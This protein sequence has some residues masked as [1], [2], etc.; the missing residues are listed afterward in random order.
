MIPEHQMPFFRALLTTRRSVALVATVLFATS[1]SDRPL[2]IDPSA[3]EPQLAASLDVASTSGVVISQVYGGGGTSG[4]TLRNDFVELFNAG[5][6][7]VTLTGWSIQYASATGTSWQVTNLTGTIQPGAYY[8][9][10][11]AQGSG[12]TANLPTPDASGSIAMSA[13]NGK[14]AL[15]L[16]QTALSGS[17][18]TTGVAD[19]VGFGSTANCFE[20]A[21]ATPTLS[22]TT[23]A[24]R[25]TNGCADTDQNGDDFTTGT[26]APRNS[27]TA[28]IVCPPPPP[29]PPATVASITPAD[30]ALEAPLNTNIA[31]TFSRAVTA[32]ATAFSL[33]CSVSGLVTTTRTGGPTAFTLDPDATL[34]Q[35]ET[36]TV[37]VQATE[38]VNAANIPMAADFT[39]SFT[40]A[41]PAACTAPFTPIFAI[42]GNGASAAITGPAVTQGVVVGDYEGPSPTL[43]GFYLQALTGDGNTATSDGIFVFNGSNNNVSLGDIVRVSGTAADFQDQTQISASTVTVCGTGTVTPV[44]VTLPVPSADYLERFE[45]MLVRFPQAL[46]VTEHFQ[47]GRFGQVVMS[48]GGRLAQPTNVFAPGAAALVLQAQNNLNRIIV[49]DALQNQNADPILFGRGGSP[50]SASSTLRGGDQATG[51][52]GVLTYTWAGNSASGN[53]YRLRPVGALGGGVPNFIAANPRPA[54][55]APVGGS[56][57]VASFN[58]LNYFNTFG[59][60]NCTNGFSGGTTD[61][62]GASNANEFERQRVKIITALAAMNAD[63]VGLMEI[64]NDG[65]GATSAVQDLVNQ[66]NA[67]TAPGRYAFIDADAGTG[68]LNALGTDG[69]KVALIYQP[70]MVTPTGRTAALN[71]VS[72]VTGGDTGP[73]NRPALAQAFLRADG[74][75]LVVAV[76]HLK[77]KG[78][79]CDAPDLNDGQGNCA[80][81]RTAAAAE[82]AAWLALDPTDTGERDALIIGDLNSYA[83]EDP[84]TAIRNAGYTNLVATFGGQD[85]YGYAF[86]GQWGYLDHALASATLGAQVTGVTKWHINADEPVALDYNTEFKTA[87]LQASLYAPDAFRSSDHDPVIVGLNLR[88]P[89]VSYTFGGFLAPIHGGTAMTL[90]DAGSTIPVRF[91]LGGDQGSNIFLAGFPA[92]RPVS[93]TTG[94]VLGGFTSANNPGGSALSYGR[95]NRVYNFGWK[96]ELAWAG[97]CRELV[98]RFQDETQ[99]RVV[100]DFR[101]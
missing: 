70:A 71:T 86:D 88:A 5:T 29:P 6:T 18:P 17:C 33:N 59:N 23:A 92:S 60:G 20:G 82:L 4:A 91:S 64:E 16:T 62:R 28:T 48:S 94:D 1:C 83:M 77:S 99:E 74:G 79:A 72:F 93:C 34:A 37:T 47:L 97:S 85:A 12:G 76:N 96:T 14:V 81:V 2:P 65:Y 30:G 35:G 39:A 13:T 95:G 21:A 66:L 45:G 78:S 40:T 89:T 25:G 44:D 68:M 46:T 27:S 26:P 49:D 63:I 101:N 80:A 84:I 52:V 69:I 54:S 73:R 19:F 51:I 87:G 24:F 50:L 36:C 8:L 7:P 67:V 9:V 15:A 10:Q 56:L 43:R 90:A 75:R 98:L 32:S 61:C 38:V 55:P 100:V 42:Q 57:T 58:V 11:Q 22:N 3:V 41:S 53:A 31:I